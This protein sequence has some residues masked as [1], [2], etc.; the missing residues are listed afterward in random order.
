MEDKNTIIQSYAYTVESLTKEMNQLTEK[1]NDYRKKDEN[2]MKELELD[3]EK[4]LNLNLSR[5]E[6][7]LLLK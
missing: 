6:N 1:L 2:L 3:K 4:M 5:L 7:P